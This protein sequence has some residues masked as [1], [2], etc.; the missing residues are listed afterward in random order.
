MSDLTAADPKPATRLSSARLVSWRWLVS[1]LIAGLFVGGVISTEGGPAALLVLLPGALPFIL[2]RTDIH[3]EV[4][5]D[6]AWACMFLINL[7][8]Y[9]P[10]FH[11]AFFTIPNLLRKSRKSP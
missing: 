4:G 5:S 2:L 9:T 7:A 11:F 8:L 6:A 10:L 1:A 3:T